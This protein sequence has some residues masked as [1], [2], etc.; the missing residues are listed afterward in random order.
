MLN[1]LSTTLILLLLAVGPC[2]APLG[3]YAADSRTRADTPNPCEGA[4]EGRLA[5]RQCND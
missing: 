3:G 2:T 1:E 4:G 5:E